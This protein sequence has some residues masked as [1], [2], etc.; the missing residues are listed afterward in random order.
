MLLEWSG[1][2]YV[3]IMMREPEPVIIDLLRSC[4]LSWTGFQIHESFKAE[5]MT[6][7]SRRILQYASTLFR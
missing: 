6:G 4:R 2:L 3:A 5:L 7:G 1:L